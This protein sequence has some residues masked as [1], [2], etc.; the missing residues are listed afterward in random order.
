MTFDPGSTGTTVTIFGGSDPLDHALSNQLDRRGCKT[1]SVTVATGWLQS[2]TH[3]IMRLDTVAG[4]EAFKQLADTPEPRSHVVAVCP[5]T[6]DA[7][8]SDRVRDLCRACGV[9]HDVA[10][11]WHP[12]LGA[13]TTAASTASTT[14]ALAATVADEM[15][16]H[17][18]VGAPAFVTRPFTFESEGH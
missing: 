2:V 18:S 14:A 3:A 5:E 6:E 15:A 1:H 4:A 9:H 12:P 10:L 7:A 8:E 11:I 17:L 13:S 16:D